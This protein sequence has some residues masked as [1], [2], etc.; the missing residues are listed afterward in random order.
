MLLV[1][2]WL[3]TKHWLTFE[4]KAEMKSRRRQRQIANDSGVAHTL[5][6]LQ[7]LSHT[8]RAYRKEAKRFL[9]CA[10]THKGKALSSMS[11]E[12]CSL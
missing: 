4:Q 1:R 7:T 8:Q 6:W 2:T 11:N 3:R 9:H 5:D 10:I 12:D